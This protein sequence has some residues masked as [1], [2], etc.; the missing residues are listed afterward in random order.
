MAHRLTLLKLECYD[1]EDWG[2]DDPYI[3][4][5]DEDEIYWGPVSMDEGDPPK[6]FNDVSPRRFDGASIAIK[7]Y[8]Q[9]NPPFDPDDELGTE[10][11]YASEA[12]REQTAEFRHDETYYKLWY[13]VDHIEGSDD[14]S[15]GPGP[16]CA[17]V[18]IIALLV[19]ASTVRG[20]YRLWMRGRRCS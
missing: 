11:A 6:T 15:P 16:S 8:E 10:I 9:D 13:R 19:I 14:D 3:K 1:K 2:K 7:L 12:G 20:V 17:L 5:G 18:L 4:L